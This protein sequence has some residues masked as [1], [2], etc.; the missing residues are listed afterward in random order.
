MYGPKPSLRLMEESVVRF[1]CEG[2]DLGALRFADINSET[3]HRKLAWQIG[4]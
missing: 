1:D 3:V 2:G 4:I